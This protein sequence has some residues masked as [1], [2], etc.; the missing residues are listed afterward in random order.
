MVTEGQAEKANDYIRDNAKTLAAAKATREYLDDFLKCKEAIL[1][2]EVKGPEHE[3]KS[4]AR[5][6][7]DYLQ[8]INDRDEARMIEVEIQ[9]RMKAAEIKIEMWRTQQANNRMIDT[10]H[11]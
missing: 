5:S 1:M 9:F 6:H 2:Q 10:S 11:Q 4:Y 7:A 8:I 3:R